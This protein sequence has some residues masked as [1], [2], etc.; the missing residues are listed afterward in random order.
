[1]SHDLSCAGEAQEEG[2]HA[3][4]AKTVPAAREWRHK[5]KGSLPWIEGEL[6]PHPV[7]GA[8]EQH[9]CQHGSL[10]SKQLL[11]QLLMVLMVPVT[12]SPGGLAGLKSAGTGSPEHRT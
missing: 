9:S 4:T 5:Q 3:C 6:S 12:G 2:Q 11:C 10:E 8:P 7:Q 1:M